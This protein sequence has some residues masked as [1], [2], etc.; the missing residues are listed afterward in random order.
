MSFSGLASEGI[1]AI[2]ERVEKAE[3]KMETF[4]TEI[5]ESGK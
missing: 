5:L 2:F 4:K 1:M 3:I